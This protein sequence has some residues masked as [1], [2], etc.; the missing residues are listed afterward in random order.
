[1]DGV[2][3][4]EEIRDHYLHLDKKDQDKDW[5]PFNRLLTLLRNVDGLRIYRL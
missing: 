2:P 3:S 4:S 1:M 5:R